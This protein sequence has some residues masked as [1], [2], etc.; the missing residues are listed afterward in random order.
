MSEYS[1]G[2]Q[3]WPVTNVC[4]YKIAAVSQQELLDLL[5]RRVETGDGGWLL[6]LNLDLLA[7]GFRDPVFQALMLSADFTF[8]DGMPLAKAAAKIN[9]SARKAGRATGSDLTRDALLRVPG[10]NIAIIGGKKPQTAIENLGLNTEDF[11]FYDGVVSLEPSDL[12]EWVKAI[13]DRSLVFVALGA[14]KQEFV[15]QYLRSKMPHAVFVGVGGSFDFLA[16]VTKRAPLW[17]QRVGLEWLFRLVSEPRRLWR[18][19]LVECPPAA[20]ELWKE[21]WRARKQSRGV[22]NGS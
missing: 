13:S 4:G 1:D 2:E 17:M 22:V 7:R 12:D 3:R 19:Y 11:F 8:A 16:G 14:P 15:I 5:V 21:T 6:A 20:V 18:R 9:P 10:K